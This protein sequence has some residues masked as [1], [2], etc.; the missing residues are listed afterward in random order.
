MA[1]SAAKA[2]QDVTMALLAGQNGMLRDVM[3]AQVVL[4]T[5]VV[6]LISGVSFPRADAVQ[7]LTEAAVRLNEH[8][9]AIKTG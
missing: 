3:S 2:E 7:D 8:L 5:V 1:K 9:D 4:C 6:A